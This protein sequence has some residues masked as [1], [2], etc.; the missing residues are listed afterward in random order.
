MTKTCSMGDLLSRLRDLQWKGDDH[1]FQEYPAPT[2]RF[3]P[4]CTSTFCTRHQRAQPAHDCTSNFLA[5]SNA[6]LQS[7]ARHISSTTRRISS[8]SSVA[9]ST[10]HYLLFSHPIQCD[11]IP[12]L[13]CYLCGCRQIPEP[14]IDHSANIF[15]QISSSDFVLPILFFIKRHSP[16]QSGIH[17]TQT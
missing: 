14:F 15:L 13:V 3:L 9:R 11:K 17:I 7:P 8:T 4:A 10:M 5:C 1:R 2:L 12:L 16:I 6:N